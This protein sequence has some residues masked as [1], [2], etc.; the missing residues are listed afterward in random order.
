VSFA[1]IRNALGFVPRYTPADAAREIAAALEAGSVVP[2][3]R[4]ITLKWYK[5]LLEWHRIIR[6]V[7]LD[8]RIL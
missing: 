4:T 5:N 8:G 6:E 7:E 2:D 1:K 3:D